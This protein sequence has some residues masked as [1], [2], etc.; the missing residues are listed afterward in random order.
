M[1][2]KEKID[3][4]DVIVKYGGKIVSA[5]G[6]CSNR[7]LFSNVFRCKYPTAYQVE[8]SRFDQLLL[9]HAAETGCEV[10]QGTQVTDFSCDQD[11]VIVRTAAGE[12][13]GHYLIDC[14]GRNSLVGTRFNLRQNYPQLRK[15]SLYA[16]FEGVDRALGGRN[17]DPDGSR[18]RP[19][20]LDHPDHYNQNQHWCCARRSD[21]Q[22]HETKPGG[23]FPPDIAREP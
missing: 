1:G 18:S 4:A 15:F 21:F 6:T 12:F 8:R 17:P 9:D 23:S 5:C 22:A 3:R 16:H 14:S 11:G 7:F 2:V 10:S 20:V 19:L 13:R